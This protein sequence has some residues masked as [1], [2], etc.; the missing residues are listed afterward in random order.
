MDNRLL[1]FAIVFNS[2]GSISPLKLTIIVFFI[3]TT[4]IGQ[5]IESAYINKLESATTIYAITN[6]TDNNN[7][8]P[9]YNNQVRSSKNLDY[10]AITYYKPDSLVSIKLD[11]SDFFKRICET[12]NDLLLFVHGDSKTFEQAI[13]RGFDIQYFHNVNVIVFSWPTK[14][15]ELNGIKNFKNSKKNAMVSV[16][17]FA[18][19]MKVMCSLP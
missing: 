9:S 2:W 15:T 7:I 13:M 11:S 14:D 4:S 19:L 12:N 3:I 18:E 10:L 8:S 1:I 17:H 16:N 6:R 5:K